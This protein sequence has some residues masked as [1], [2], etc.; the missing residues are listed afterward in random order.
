MRPDPPEP[1]PRHCPA[2][3]DCRAWAYD[4]RTSTADE[5]HD[6]LL[7]DRCDQARRA[8][9][10]W[11][12]RVIP[13]LRS[14]TAIKDL[15]LAHP[16]TS[17]APL[18]TGLI[19]PTTTYLVVADAER[20]GVRAPAAYVGLVSQEPT[21]RW[22]GVAGF[23][24]PWCPRC[25][26]DGIETIEGYLPRLL[27]ELG[28]TL[29]PLHDLP[30]SL[31]PRPGWFDP[32]RLLYGA[33]V[34]HDPSIATLWTRCSPHLR[35]PALVRVG[36]VHTSLTGL[37]LLGGGDPLARL[38]DALDEDDESAANWTCRTGTADSLARLAAL[39]SE[40]PAILHSPRPNSPAR[41]WA[42]AIAESA[43]FTSA[44]RLARTA[45][46]ARARV[47]ADVRGF[48]RPLVRS[49]V[50]FGKGAIRLSDLERLREALT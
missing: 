18:R 40:P 38:V 23:F 50:L 43:H 3:R 36:P 31:H 15:T 10:D 30:G 4:P 8:L 34:N 48:P 29:T 46:A 17:R 42:V 32:D 13:P 45:R 33:R 14:T 47:L 1:A 28:V 24:L 6:D 19:D 21:T 49:A 25:D 2:A 9:E 35:G 27:R 41:G 39:P 22:T 12:V 7:H 37:V 11:L 20:S 26:P 44:P 5:P 16:Q